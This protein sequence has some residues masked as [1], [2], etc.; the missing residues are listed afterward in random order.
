MGRIRV[1]P[2]KASVVKKHGVL[3]W[4]YR[5]LPV[6]NLLGTTAIL[7]KLFEII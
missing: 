2:N 4:A 3:Y 5:A 7:L 1:S 6:I